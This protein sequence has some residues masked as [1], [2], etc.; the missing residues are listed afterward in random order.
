L[1]YAGGAGG[2]GGG[3]KLQRNDSNVSLSGRAFEGPPSYTPIDQDRAGATPVGALKQVD[4][5]IFGVFSVVSV[6][7]I[8]RMPKPTQSIG[9]PVTNWKNTAAADYLQVMTKT[10]GIPS[11]ID[12]TPGGLAIWKPEFLANGCLFRIEVRDEAILH[13][14]PVNHFDFVYITVRY[15][16][17]PSRFMDVT[18]LTNTITYDQAKSELTARCG[19]VEG[20]IAIL[21]LATQ[22]GQGY[23]SINYAVANNLLDRYQESDKSSVYDLLCYNVKHCVAW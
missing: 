22:I 4:D 3:S 1:I 21:A 18:T 14:Y 11:A 10:F 12:P 7:S 17:A 16:V 23:I 9:C 5:G 19:T 2:A 13:R 6:A 8:A 20:A 15:R